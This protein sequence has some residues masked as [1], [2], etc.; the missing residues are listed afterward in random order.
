MEND[1][2][3]QAPP[4]DAYSVRVRLG[5]SIQRLRGSRDVT[6]TARFQG[7]LRFCKAADGI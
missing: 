5:R 7:S 6:Q 4:P 3:F 1:G 2:R